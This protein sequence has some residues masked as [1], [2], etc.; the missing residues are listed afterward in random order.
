MKSRQGKIVEADDLI[1]EVTEMAEEA[2]KK[3]WPEL[4]SAEV[5]NRAEKI[6]M[7]SILFTYGRLFSYVTNRVGCHQVP[8]SF[9]PS[10][11][12]HYL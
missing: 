4:D 7:M 11:Y 8:S 12:Y 1:A 6:G 5:R 9:M 10:H 2:T 3:R